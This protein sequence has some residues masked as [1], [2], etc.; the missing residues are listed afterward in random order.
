MRSKLKKLPII[1]AILV[2]TLPSKLP[3][4]ALA[5]PPYPSRRFEDDLEPYTEDVSTGLHS[6]CGKCSEGGVN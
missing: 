4:P 1:A 5:Q 6:A 2:I 3:N